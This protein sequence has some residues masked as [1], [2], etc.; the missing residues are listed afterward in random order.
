MR[1]QRIMH[2]V[3]HKSQ[4]RL[5]HFATTAKFFAVANFASL[6]QKGRAL[7]ASS[8]NELKAGFSPAFL[9]WH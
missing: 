8:P 6:T 9:F 1:Q 2:R 4:I 3:T 5:A 7:Q